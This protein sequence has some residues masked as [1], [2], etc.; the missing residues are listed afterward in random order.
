MAGRSDS[1]KSKSIEL[2]LINWHSQVLQLCRSLFSTDYSRHEVTRTV[3]Q[4]DGVMRNQNKSPHGVVDINLLAVIIVVENLQ[5]AWWGC[6]SVAQWKGHEVV[7]GRDQP[8]FVVVTDSQ[9][10][11][12]RLAF[13]SIALKSSLR[14]NV[15]SLN[16]V[17]HAK[18]V[19]S[20]WTRQHS[21]QS[22]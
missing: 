3:G 6:I 14:L 22:R 18:Y 13:Q 2:E 8:Q 20:W 5:V 4:S 10:L 9:I 11:H 15:I 7:V 19:Q 17:P 21:Q 12:V 16:V 1:F